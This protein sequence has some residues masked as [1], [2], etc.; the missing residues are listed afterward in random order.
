MLREQAN[1]SDAPAPVRTKSR[2]VRM[3][4]TRKK[5]DDTP[6]IPK[7]P[8]VTSA[9]S[10]EQREAA[11]RARGLLPPLPLS[12]QER[13][14][15]NSIP[16]V[17]EVKPEPETSKK[18]PTAADLIKKQWEEKNREA[19]AEERMRLN[20]FRFGGSSTSLNEPK[21]PTDQSTSEPS[22]SEEHA[23]AT[24][25]DAKPSRPTVVT[26][27]IKRQGMHHASLSQP[28]R[29]Q[30]D[31]L[32]SPADR[33]T[34][35]HLRSS[36]LQQT[37][38]QDLTGK[39]AVTPIQDLPTEFQAYLNSQPS[40]LLESKDVSQIASSS[41]TASPAL[42]MSPP[43]LP[44]KETHDHRTPTPVTSSQ[45]DKSLPIPE[46]TSIA[47]LGVPGE[48]LASNGHLDPPQRAR[49]N[50][51]SIATPS[52]DSTSSTSKSN[53]SL[54][55]GQ[56]PKLPPKHGDHPIVQEPEDAT[57][58]LAPVPAKAGSSNDPNDDDD[59]E[60]IPPPS[61]PPRETGG[62]RKRGTADTSLPPKEKVAPVKPITV[63]TPTRKKTLN[64][65]KR[66]AQKGGD[67]EGT[68]AKRS[69]AALGRSVVGTVRTPSR[70]PTMPNMPLSR[71]A[72]RSI[73]PTSPMRRQMHFGREPVPPPHPPVVRQ[74]VN[75][76]F[77]SGGDIQAQTAAIEDDE[78]RRMAEMA[79]LS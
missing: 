23:A 20:T 3:L 15:D 1:T 5:D 48:T 28:M 54:S 51:S 63:N 45:D 42:Q 49:S 70:S 44:L 29:I 66:N 69:L 62:M 61:V 77:Y 64:P 74:A 2:L 27:A 36:S 31:A 67:D 55:N 17:R 35:G 21:K 78:E 16:I 22:N 38:S 34:N 72:D 75:P 37:N 18:E 71:P 14:L 19:N 7:R 10:K 57:E 32:R 43:T 47:T 60:L 41:P 56:P 65:F 59:Y 8:A 76:A 26:K 13:A 25:E 24:D 46:A 33:T 40:P 30:T 52:L 73:S 4:T 58:P 50:S 9:Y 11:L 6:K 12:E 39:Q 79:F 68:G 53:G